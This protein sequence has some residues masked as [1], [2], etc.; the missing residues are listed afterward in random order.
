MNPA[1]LV[2]PAKINLHLEIKGLREDGYHEL[3]TLFFP[4]DMPCDLIKIEPGHDEHFYIRCPEKP[5]LETTSNLM[6]MAWKRFGETTGFQPGIFVTLTKR[7]PMGGG[8]G[9][10]SSNAAA[11]L[12]WLNAEAG[13]KAL[14][15]EAMLSL[16]ASLGADVPFFLMDG[17]AWATGIGEVLEPAMVTLSEMTLLIACPDIKVSTPW[18]F[19]AWDKKN[20]STKVHQSLTTRE[21]GTKTPSPVS[22]REMTNDFEPVVFE[23]HPRLQEIKEK[24][25][26]SGAEAAA[27]SGSGASLFGIFA[28]RDSAKKAAKALEEDGIEI[29]MMDCR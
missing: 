28:D 19:S 2:A 4:V 29:F 11:M 3:R 20:N 21:S 16:A 18:A 23:K 25:I 14:S 24:I 13:D 17:P 6:Y 1:T 8:L 22:P 15:Q 10:G 7:I 9:G 12:T 26:N 5:E 27:M